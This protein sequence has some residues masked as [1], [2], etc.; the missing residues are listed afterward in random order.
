M[1]LT[2]KIWLSEVG[3]NHVN[4]SDL[5]DPENEMWFYFT[6]TN[7]TNS[8]C[9]GEAVFNCTFHSRDVITN[10]AVVALKAQVQE[11]RAKAEKEVTELNEKINQLLAIEN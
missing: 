1:Q 4:L 9:I 8:T 10:N 3:M 11:V 5:S 2:R 6:N 7:M